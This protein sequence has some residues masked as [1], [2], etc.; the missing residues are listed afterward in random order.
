MK[1]SICF[2]VKLIPM[3]GFKWVFGV[4]KINNRVVKINISLFW[5]RKAIDKEG[6]FYLLVSFMELLNKSILSM[7]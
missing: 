7:N 3:S 6:L 4:V 1:L 5:G 2:T